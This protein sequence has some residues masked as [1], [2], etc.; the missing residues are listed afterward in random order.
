MR[1]ALI[2]GAT[3]LV[4]VGLMLSIGAWRSGDLPWQ[5]GAVS[6]QSVRDADLDAMTWKLVRHDGQRIGPQDWAG[7]TNIV[8][9]G[10]TWCPDVCPLTLSNI[11]GWLEELGP[12]ADQVGVHLLS[13]D[14][15]RDSPDVLAA[16]LQSF[17][18][19]IN[20]L[21]GT[22]DEVAA[23]AAAFGASYQ[24]IEREDGDY[25]MDHT[26]GVFV[27]GSDGRLSSIIDLH[28]DP[29]FAVP[30]IRRAMTSEA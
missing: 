10:F 25:T 8:F 4:S 6:V 28:D 21:T 12:D 1:R 23:A 7:R 13:V 17:D 19:R 3:A 30:K 26:A 11:A 5:S 29:E 18:K 2:F 14:P 15:E 27:F 9:F 24:R 20:G 16:Y 22:P